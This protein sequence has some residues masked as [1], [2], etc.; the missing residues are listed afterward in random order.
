M[1]DWIGEEGSIIK[2]Q[3]SA[4]KLSEINSEFRLCTSD[5]IKRC[6]FKDKSGKSHKIG[7]HTIN[8]L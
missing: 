5:E 1:V 7:E 6:S 8:T 3:K 2:F 4:E